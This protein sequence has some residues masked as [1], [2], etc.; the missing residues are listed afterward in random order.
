[1]SPAAPP[2]SAP[3]FERSKPG[4]KK[5]PALQ[6]FPELPTP[7]ALEVRE[8]RLQMGWML[9][10]T[11]DLIGLSDAQSVSEIER[12]ARK[13]TNARWTIMLLAAQ[14]HPTLKLVPVNAEPPGEPPL[15]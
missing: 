10:Q 5:A 11:A 6:I 13:M 8:L 3:A 4:P 12:G 9:A 7:T 2:A 1:M 14:R 15:P